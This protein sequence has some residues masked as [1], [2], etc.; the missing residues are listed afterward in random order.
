MCLHCVLTDLQLTAKVLHG[1]F[2]IEADFI[3]READYL[4]AKFIQTPGS[5]VILI[6][7]EFVIFPVNLHDNLQFEAI[8]VCNRKPDLIATRPK[9]RMLTVKFQAKETS[10][11]YSFPENCF[12]IGGSS[13]QSP[14][15]SFCNREATLK[16]LGITNCI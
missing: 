15:S 4:N 8:K 12:R 10:A 16:Y 6:C 2:E 9:E 3:V 14:T 5:L 11:S 13:T 1:R 7:S